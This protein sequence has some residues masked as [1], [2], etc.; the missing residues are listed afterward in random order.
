MNIVPALGSLSLGIVV[1]WLI[2]FFIRRF[3]SFTPKALTSIVSIIAGGATVKLLEADNTVLWFY[4][5]GLLGGFLIYT[6]LALW[7]LGI[8]RSFNS[9]KNEPYNNDKNNDNSLKDHDYDGVLYKPKSNK[10]K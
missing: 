9:N 7:A 8:P 2:R 6:M 5:I 3:K 10:N 1:G 4:P